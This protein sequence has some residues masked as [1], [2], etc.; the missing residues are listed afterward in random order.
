[1]SLVNELAEGR[2][3]KL[4]I[5]LTLLLALS[6][7]DFA[8]LVFGSLEE[9]PCPDSAKVGAKSRLAI[10]KTLPDSFLPILVSQALQRFFADP[11]IMFPLAEIIHTEQKFSW[12]EPIPFQPLTVNISLDKLRWLRK[13]A[14]LQISMSFT[15]G[16][17]EVARAET[18]LWWR[19]KSESASKNAW[20]N[21]TIKAED[22][23]AQ[24]GCS[25][26]HKTSIIHDIARSDIRNYARLS[27]D[28]NPIHLD[29]QVA[30]HQ[31]FP[32]AIAHG[33]YLC[34]LTIESLDQLLE[35]FLSGVI[36]PSKVIKSETKSGKTMK[37]KLHSFATKFVQPF[38]LPSH[39][40]ERR[41]FCLNLIPNM[42][43]KTNGQDAGFT[44]E[45]SYPQDFIFDQDI[46]ALG[47]M[48]FTVIAES[49]GVTLFRNA[50]VEISLALDS[51]ICNGQRRNR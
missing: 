20:K 16:Q 44:S 2:I 49:L 14:Q 28:D 45:P 40:D 13:I 15:Q 3:P 4:P 47:R 25:A 34:H 10:A 12:L 35:P 43:K 8:G 42:N 21:S 50:E 46:A 9:S 23:V 30:Q 17:I 24:A 7:A 18:K 37:I 51:D 22:I 6:E 27:G 48:R 32:G 26:S 33:L 38:I 11:Q 1:M 31:G 41:S 39:E 29:D 5:R 36:K 19:P